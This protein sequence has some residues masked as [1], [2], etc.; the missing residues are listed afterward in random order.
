MNL[1]G[2]RCSP[3]AAQTFRRAVRIIDDSETAFEKSRE[4]WWLRILAKISPELKKY[5]DRRAEAAYIRRRNLFL[6]GVSKRRI[7]LFNL[8]KPH[9][10][11][12][13]K[14]IRESDTLLRELRERIPQPKEGDSK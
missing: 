12:Y 9:P 10:G 1:N 6:A 4:R 7:R 3:R 11:R 5:L 14:A 8:K 2:V 13:E